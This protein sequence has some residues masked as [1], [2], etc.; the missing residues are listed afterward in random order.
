[1]FKRN[2]LKISIVTVCYNM[3]PYIENTIK[4]VLSQEYPNL[5]YI[6]IDGDSTDGTQSIIEKYKDKLSYYISEPDAGMYDAIHKGIGKATGDIVAWLNADDI[7]MPWTFSTVNE[8]FS[9]YPDVEWIG[10]KHAFL[11]EKGNLSQICS[12]TSLRSRNDISSGWC[13]DGIFGPLQQESMFWRRNL[14]LQAGG[15]DV[16]FKYA[17]DFDLWMR[18]AQMANLIKLELPIAAFR[19]RSS[20]LSRDGKNFYEEEVMR[21]CAGKRKYPNVIWRFFG[22]NRLVNQIM[23]MLTIRKNFVLYYDLDTQK[24]KK[25]EL[26]GNVSNHCVE[27][28]FLYR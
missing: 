2:Y 4:S 19:R 27:S 3:A 6:V 5:E 22:R 25:K 26:I 18:F 8:I 14:Y 20:S 11:N 10:G 7:Y 23:R 1:M 13:R 17:G 12:G 24:L 21:A 9:S 28:L 15:L 16:S